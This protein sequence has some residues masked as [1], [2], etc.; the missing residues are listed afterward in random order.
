MG[1]ACCGGQSKD[2]SKIRYGAKSVKY[3]KRVSN[4]ASLRVSLNID[5]DPLLS[6]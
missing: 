5:K 6:D 3:D 2:K 4:R 1:N